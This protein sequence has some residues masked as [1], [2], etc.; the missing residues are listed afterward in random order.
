MVLCDQQDT[1][2]L[3]PVPGARGTVFDLVEL[4]ELAVCNDE[5]MDFRAGEDGL[6]FGFF[7]QLRSFGQVTGPLRASVSSSL[8]QSNILLRETGGDYT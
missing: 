1:T 6:N 4:T 5:G 3:N 7:P 8:S 2:V